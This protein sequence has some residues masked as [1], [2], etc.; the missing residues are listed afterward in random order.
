MKDE[1]EPVE[2]QVAPRSRGRQPLGW[3]RLGQDPDRKNGPARGSRKNRGRQRGEVD[4][5]IL[6]F[7]ALGAALTLVLWYGRADSSMRTGLVTIPVLVGVSLPIIS[8]VA[9][10]EKRFDLAGLMAFS[11]A[12]R[13]AFSVPRFRG[14]ADSSVY[15]TVGK[16]LSASFR[17]LDFTV[18]TG[19][20]I[21]GTGSV[22][23]LTGLVQVFTFD[24]FYS[25]LLVFTVF[26]FWGT[27]FFYRAFTLAVPDARHYRY[28]KLVFLWPSILFWTSSIGKEAC[29]TFTIGLASL[30]LAMVIVRRWCGFVWVVLGVTTTVMIR[31]HMGMV[32]GVAVLSV[33]L[34][35]RGAGGMNLQFGAR[36]VALVV[37]LVGGS[38]LAQTTA[39]F[40]N[41]ENLGN[42]SIET[43]FDRTEFMTDQGGS[44]FTAARVQTPADYP[45][46]VVTVLFRPFPFEAHTVEAIATSAEGLF[47]LGLVAVSGRSLLA[48]PGAVRKFSYVGFAAVFV[49][50]FCFVFSVIGNFGILARQRTQVLP[51]LFVLVSLAVG[52][53]AGN[54]RRGRG[55]LS[56]ATNNTDTSNNA[57]ESVGIDATH[58]VASNVRRIMH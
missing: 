34:M 56:S 52:R 29:M 53:S 16:S 39:E 48:V 11:I 4:W 10:G 45:W 26:A 28:A 14:G 51:L 17:S 3:S 9:K 12:A 6:A 2:S 18:E 46:A 5:R 20:Q 36:I 23:Y 37:L 58:F 41:L 54:K 7:L 31:P 19:R 40:L 22:R 13:M 33:L 49:L 42:E 44:N 24:D 25:T 21:P 55:R 1:T 8:K 30:G 47:L 43:A 38:I 50:V 35:P 32:F 27:W 15:H 57:T